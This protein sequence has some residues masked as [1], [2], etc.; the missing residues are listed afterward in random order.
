[1]AR[2]LR[3][4]ILLGV[5]VA[6]LAVAAYL[7]ARAGR[8]GRLPDRYTI[9]G[10]CLKC[11]QEAQITFDATNPQPFECADC[12]ER[13]VYEWMYCFECKHRFVPKLVK[14]PDQP[15]QFPMIPVCSDCGTQ[16]VGAYL[17]IDPEQEP[18]GDHPLPEMP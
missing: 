5:A 13:S 17:P 8:E 7:F 4:R 18:I 16:R 10:V 3:Q 9:E 15:P 2:S 1:M 6:G 11:E 12:G 14:R